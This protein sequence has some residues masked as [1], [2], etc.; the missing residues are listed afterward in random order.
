MKKW[1]AENIKQWIEERPDWFKI[2]KIPDEYLPNDVLDAEGGLQR[3]RSSLL[4]IIGLEEGNKG[5]IYPQV[6]EEM[7]VEEL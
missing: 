2:E 6:D 4:E 1:V 5:R 3:R 7:K